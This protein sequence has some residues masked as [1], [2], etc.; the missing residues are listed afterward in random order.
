MS[1]LNS[2]CR[3][4]STDCGRDL[5]EQLRV[6]RSDKLFQLRCLGQLRSPSREH[7]V[8]EGED[9]VKVILCRSIPTSPFSKLSTRLPPR[10]SN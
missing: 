9:N 6:R 4:R 3:G 5:G 1:G 7:L 8:H 2:P 10:E